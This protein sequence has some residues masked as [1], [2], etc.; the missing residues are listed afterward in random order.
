MFDLILQFILD[1]NEW[2]GRW[3]KS[4]NVV[5]FP[6]GKMIY[7]EDWVLMHG[8]RKAKTVSKFSSAFEDFVRTKLTRGEFLTEASK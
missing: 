3:F 6:W 1:L 8:W 7:M 2:W 4:I 5:A